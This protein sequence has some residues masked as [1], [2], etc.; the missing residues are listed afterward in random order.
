MS[1]DA[2]L[3]VDFDIRMTFTRIGTPVVVVANGRGNAASKAMLPRYEGGVGN[4]AAT[5][6]GGGLD[7]L[8]ALNVLADMIRDR[9]PDLR[10]VTR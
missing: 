6:S 2:Q 3:D 8:E 10:I 5:L 7:S 9:F 1:D 4:G